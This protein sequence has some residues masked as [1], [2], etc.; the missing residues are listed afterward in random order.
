[1]LAHSSYIRSGMCNTYTHFTR[2]RTRTFI[3]LFVHI[4]VY[5]MEILPLVYIPRKSV[6]E[7]VC[8]RPAHILDICCPKQ[9]LSHTSSL[10]PPS[11]ILFPTHT[12]TL[13]KRAAK[14]QYRRA[15]SWFRFLSS[16]VRVIPCGP[17]IGGY[18]V[19]VCVCVCVRACV[20]AC[21]CVC[22]CSRARVCVCVRACVRACV[23]VC[24]CVC[25]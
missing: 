8:T 5:S 25:V 17:A 4:R 13:S 23:C 2:T 12:H 10:Q 14:E 16:C 6:D 3:L 7:F 22:V 11:L 15:R 1:M 18:A 9:S 21:V 19:C 20:R 24:V